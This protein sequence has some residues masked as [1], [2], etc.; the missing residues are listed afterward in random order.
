MK[1][2]CLFGNKYCN[3]QSTYQS[4]AW[5]TVRCWLTNLGSLRGTVVSSC[6]VT[7]L[8]EATAYSQWDIR[9]SANG[10]WAKWESADWWFTLTGLERARHFIQTV[11]IHGWWV[12]DYW[13]QLYKP[14]TRDL[15]YT[16]II[17]CDSG[18]LRQTDIVCF[19]RLQIF[20]QWSVS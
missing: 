8:S 1:V 20:D 19:T 11:A 15:F 17:L 13:K 4:P 3:W 9:K 10:L 16:D 6:R 5:A 14:Y 7:R 2:L 12:E 18:S